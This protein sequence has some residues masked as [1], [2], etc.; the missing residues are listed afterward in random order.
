LGCSEKAVRYRLERFNTEG[1][2]GLGDRPGAGRRPRIPSSAV[3]R[4]MS[5]ARSALRLVAGLSCGLG[6]F[7]TAEV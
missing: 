1:L 6:P 2:D 3:R 4:H 5:A 7:G